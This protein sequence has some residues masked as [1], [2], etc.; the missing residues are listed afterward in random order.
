M[1]TLATIRT[2]LSKLPLSERRAI[3]RRVKLKSVD[4]NFLVNKEILWKL[5]PEDP[6][7]NSLPS[8]SLQHGNCDTTPPVPKRKNLPSRE[9]PATPV[10]NFPSYGQDYDGGLP[11][12]VTL[13]IFSLRRR[14]AELQS[15][16]IALNNK[17]TKALECLYSTRRFI[18]LWIHEGQGESFDSVER[19]LKGIGATIAHIEDRNIGPSPEMEIPERWKKAKE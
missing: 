7:N 14:N 1:R 15:K 4:K 11:D 18:T 19:R 17:L 9:F 8:H 13:E 6:V 2:M 12:A 10:N 5:C 3:L 16:V